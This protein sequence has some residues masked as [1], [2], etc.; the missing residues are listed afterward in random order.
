MAGLSAGKE[1]DPSAWT[2]IAGP[3]EV[4]ATSFTGSNY[5]PLPFTIGIVIPPGGQVSFLI[6]TTDTCNLPCVL[7]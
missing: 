5:V 7:P 1:L 2:L 4:N 3:A 6:T